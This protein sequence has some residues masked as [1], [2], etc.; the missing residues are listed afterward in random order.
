[1]ARVEA[2]V[3]DRDS[4]PAIDADQADPEGSDARVAV[5]ADS[6]IAARVVGEVSVGDLVEPADSDPVET[7]MEAPLPV[8]DH[9]SVATTSEDRVAVGAA[10]LATARAAQADHMTVQGALRAAADSKL[11]KMFSLS[12]FI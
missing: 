12:F 1:M 10:A 8:R 5:G 4:A 9:T 2:V 6:M 7:D 11:K 3:G